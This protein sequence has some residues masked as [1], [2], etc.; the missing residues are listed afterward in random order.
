MPH[1]SR[2]RQPARKVGRTFCQSSTKD[3]CTCH[4][5]YLVIVYITS[6]YSAHTLRK[7]TNSLITN[8]IETEIISLKNHKLACLDKIAAMILNLD[9]KTF[10]FSYMQLCKNGESNDFKEKITVILPKENNLIVMTRKVS[11]PCLTL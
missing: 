3:K 6:S 1:C 7:G 2:Y 10:Q 9:P 4:L 5:P 11:P 8:D